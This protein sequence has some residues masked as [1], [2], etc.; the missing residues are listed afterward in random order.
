MY[1]FHLMLPPPVAMSPAT[2]KTA[3]GAVVPIPTRAL[4]LR[5]VIAVVFN[6]GPVVL[7][8]SLRASVVPS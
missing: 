1:V 5:I 4:V 2:S 8:R 6:W 3:P 7:V